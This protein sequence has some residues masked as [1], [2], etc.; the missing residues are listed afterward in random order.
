MARIICQWTAQL[1][2]RFTEITLWGDKI[3]HTLVSIV[4][5]MTANGWGLC[6]EHLE[7]IIL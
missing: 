5:I 6:R 3:T 2:L 7:V 4:D 1:F